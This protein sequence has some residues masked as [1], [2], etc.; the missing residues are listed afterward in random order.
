MLWLTQLWF[1]GLSS[2][3]SVNLL[4]AALCL[5]AAFGAN[6]RA[7]MALSAVLYLWLVFL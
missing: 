4:F 7:V 5:A 3:Q 2:P 1:A 6:G